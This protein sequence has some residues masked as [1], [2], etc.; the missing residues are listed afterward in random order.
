MILRKIEQI[1]DKDKK[2]RWLRGLYSRL[3]SVQNNLI[4]LRFK[5][6]VFGTKALFRKRILGEISKEFMVENKDKITETLTEVKQVVGN[7]NELIL[8]LNSLTGEIINREN[9]VGKLLYDDE[10]L[11]NIKTLL[12]QVKELTN[13]LLEQLKGEGLKVDAEVDLF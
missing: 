11:N 2:D 9:N 12:K 4:T 7:T 6:V 13:I 8:K 10:L 5:P 3:S 1:K